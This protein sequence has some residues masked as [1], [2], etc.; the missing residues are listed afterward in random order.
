M[1]FVFVISAPQLEYRIAPWNK[2]SDQFKV[3]VTRS[4]GVA[5]AVSTGLAAV[6]FYV[7]GGPLAKVKTGVLAVAILFAIALLVPIYRAITVAC[8][9][10][11]PLDV[12]SVRVW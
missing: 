3:H 5:A 10:W 9:R 2:V 4:L 12:I 1:I 11:G 8:W 7:D 6:S